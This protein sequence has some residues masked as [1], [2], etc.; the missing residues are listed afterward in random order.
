MAEKAGRFGTKSIKLEVTFYAI[1]SIFVN[2]IVHAFKKAYK[3]C[4]Q[5]SFFFGKTRG[6]L[7]F[8]GLEICFCF[9]K[10]KTNNKTETIWTIGIK[11]II[12]SYIN[13]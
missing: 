12:T 2:N 6:V 10:K 7:C 5:K 3:I 11:H 4:E 9:I 8:F 1:R 13:L